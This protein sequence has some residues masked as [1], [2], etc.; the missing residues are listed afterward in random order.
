MS[1]F[2]IK[3]AHIPYVE[4]HLMNKKYLSLILSGLLLS[5][6]SSEQEEQHNHTHYE[7]T[8][9]PEATVGVTISSIDTN[10][11]FQGAYK[12]YQ[13]VGE[14]ESDLTVLLESASNNQQLQDS[15]FESMKN[16]GAKA[17]VI[18]LVDV[19]KGPE[20]IKKYCGQLPLVFFN[21][22][23]GDKALASCE[24]AYF[25][26]G[27]A[28]QA[29]ML[30]G[31]QVLEHWKKN[32]AWDK[33]RDGTIQFAIV[34]G[35]PNHAGAMARTKWAISTMQ[36]YP[37]L[38]VPVQKIFSD[39]AMFQT[40]QAKDL[41]KKWMAMP[42]FSQV[43]VILAN[44]DSMAIGVIE[45]LK[46]GGVKLPIFGIDGTDVANNAVKSG[47]MVATVFNDYDNQARTSLRLAANL[48]AGKPA[49][50][51]IEYKMHY[52]VVQIPYKDLSSGHDHAHDD[53]AH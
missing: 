43:E 45:A 26:D 31:L 25:V 24:H 41:V 16:K 18:N 8:P 44:N 12:S 34:E 52:K 15:Q 32:P 48:A 22:N 46:E 33:N 42:Q 49:M 50:S 2:V 27:D 13:K 53:K 17:L 5:A 6:C 11:F 23:P 20:I 10:P 51:G 38:G 21:R 37:A 35:I 40:A 47:D 19:Q 30:Q 28:S 3:Y 36:N 14:E 9:Y 39:Y 7:K 4:A 29:G 1:I